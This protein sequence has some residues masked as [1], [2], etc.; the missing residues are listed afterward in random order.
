VVVNTFSPGPRIEVAH[1]WLTV[2]SQAEAAIEQLLSKPE[3]DD[4]DIYT[5]ATI[6]AYL[7]LAKHERDF[8]QAWTYINL[9]D[10]YLPL[11]VEKEEVIACCERLRMIDECLPEKVKNQLFTSIDRATDIQEFLRQETFLDKRELH[12]MRHK[13]HS[14]QIIRA[15][16]WNVANR[17]VSLKLSAWRALGFW[18]FCGLVVAV[19][20]ATEM[21]TDISGGYIV[22][23]KAYLTSTLTQVTLLGFF[24]GGL[25]AFLTARQKAISVPNFEEIKVYTLLR[26]L[27]GAAGAF[28]FYVVIQWPGLLAQPLYNEIKTNPYII[29]SLGI[30]AGFSERLF[31]NTLEKI[32]EK[33]H[34]TGNLKALK[35]YLVDQEAAGKDSGSD[36]HGSWDDAPYP[37]AR[38]PHQA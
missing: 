27:L 28:V 13:T 31:I 20:I 15:H 24:G 35:M 3:V 25:S 38:L 34:M 5:L 1:D 17:T 23:L 10:A 18:L 29:I 19:C 30:I 6:R 21:T 11:V 4:S 22:H 26:M 36:E 37:Q 2:Y 14:E 7:E 12:A 33:L 8:A 9:A 32:T 16:L